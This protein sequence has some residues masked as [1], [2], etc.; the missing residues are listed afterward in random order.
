VRPSSFSDLVRDFYVDGDIG[1]IFTGRYILRG[2]EEDKIRE[3]FTP[4]LAPA[5]ESLTPE[6]H[7]HIEGMGTTLILYRAGVT[8]RADQLPAFLYQTALIA[9]TFFKLCGLKKPVA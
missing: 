2:P 7:W 8:V 1:S 9:R 3:L 4:A 5:L 6:G